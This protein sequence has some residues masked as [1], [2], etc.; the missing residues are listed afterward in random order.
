MYLQAIAIDK[1]SL[2]ED[3]PSLAIYFNNLAGLYKSQGRYTE[4][5]PLYLEALRICDI[6]DRSLS[7]EHPNTVTAWNNFV[8]FLVQVVSEGKESVLSEHPVV[9][10]LLTK[11]KEEGELET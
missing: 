3:H 2:P 4:A 8:Y 6:C 5:E 1:Q 9:Q 11:I 10:E 7:S